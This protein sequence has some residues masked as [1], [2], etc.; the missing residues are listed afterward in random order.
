V[1]D[2]RE[3]EARADVLVYTSD[4]LDDVLE[5]VGPVHAD[6][7]VSSSLDHTDFFVRLCD[8]HPNEQS[9]N[10]CDGLQ[11]FRPSDIARRADGT[12]T[13]RVK[14]W[15]TAYRFGAGHRVRVQVSSG[16]HPVYVRNLG[17]A[18]PLL[19]AT[20]LRVAEQAVFR[21]RSRASSLVLPH[22]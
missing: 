15:D 16:A 10:V 17:T 1:V 11:R 4:V 5:I 21:D 3:L 14:M 13:A 12:F 18:E 19:A 2:N 6:L 8:V 22:A 9:Y 7:V 20:T